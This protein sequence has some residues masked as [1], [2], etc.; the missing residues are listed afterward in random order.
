MA[1]SAARKLASSIL[2]LEPSL[3][4]ASTSL[5]CSLMFFISG[6]DSAI[7]SILKMPKQLFQSSKV[8][9]TVFAIHALDQSSQ[10]ESIVSSC[11]YSVVSSKDISSMHFL[12]A[13]G[14][15][16]SLIFTAFNLVSNST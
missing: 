14:K 2:S 5:I 3:A 11:S 8:Y 1:L 6:L 15:L 4:G 13:L 9:F 12:L 10:L 7:T 16:V